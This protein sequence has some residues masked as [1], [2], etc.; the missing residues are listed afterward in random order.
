MT[1]WIRVTL[2]LLYAERVSVTTRLA[3]IDRDIRQL[4]Q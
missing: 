4:E 3:E 1:R 2:A